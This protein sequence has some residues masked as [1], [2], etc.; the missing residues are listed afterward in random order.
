MHCFWLLPKYNHPFLFIKI[1]RYTRITIM[2]I[3]NYFF[4]MQS[5]EKIPQ[6]ANF[7]TV[8]LAM[9]GSSLS[10]LCIG[11]LHSLTM[12]TAELPI[13]IAPF[14]ASAVLVFGAIKSPLAQP[15]NVILGHCLS[16][17]IGITVYRFVQADETIII[18]LAVSLAIGLMLITNTVHPPGGATAFITASGGEFIEKL[19]YWYILCPCLFGTVS[20]ILLAVL[21]NNL[22]PKHKYPLFW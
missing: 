22:S 7:S 6:K 4:K 21:I 2:K 15:R 1:V 10:L 12:D 17:F 11:Y 16:A 20:M 8:F 5:T 9:I 18:S 14:G 19:G 3:K 13:L